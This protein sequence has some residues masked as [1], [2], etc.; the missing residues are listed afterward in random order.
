MSD[1]PKTFEEADKWAEEANVG[2]DF[3]PKWKWDCNFKLDYDG[4]IISFS[5]RFYPPHKNNHDGWEGSISVYI[6]DEKIDDEAFK[7]STLEELKVA[8]ERSANAY[9]QTVKRRM[10]LHI[11]DD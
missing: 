3:G 11:K 2:R 7:E 1:C 10:K 5:S 6:L 9:I 8:V 4:E